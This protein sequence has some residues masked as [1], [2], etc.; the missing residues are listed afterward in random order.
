MAK[1]CRWG[2]SKG[3]RN[4]PGVSEKQ[5]CLF[6]ETLD[7]H[8]PQRE[9][10]Q[11]MAALAE[12]EV[13]EGA[14]TELGNFTSGCCLRWTLSFCSLPLLSSIPRAHQA[15]SNTSHRRVK[16]PRMVW[17]GKT[18]EI[19]P[20]HPG[21]PAQDPKTDLA[22]SGYGIGPFGRVTLG[23]DRAQGTGRE[24]ELH[25]CRNTQLHCIHTASLGLLNHQEKCKPHFPGLCFFFFPFPSG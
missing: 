2:S 22:G 19:I 14:E 17:I 1:H 15:A 23:Q 11:V 12:V 8:Q 10:L 18:L 25:L 7:A 6:M 9:E 20:F 21:L 13:A 3:R 24:T 16:N 4:P 5:S